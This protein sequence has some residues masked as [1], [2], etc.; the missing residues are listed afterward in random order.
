MWTWEGAG[1]GG[2][3]MEKAGRGAFGIAGLATGRDGPATAPA[4]GVA[5]IYKRVSHSR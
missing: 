1:A 3:A 4:N 5:T 2:T